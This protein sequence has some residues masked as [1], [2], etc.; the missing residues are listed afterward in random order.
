MDNPRKARVVE[1]HFLNLPGFNAGAYVRAYVQDTTHDEMR[2]PDGKH[3]GCAPTPR[4]VLEIADCY[5]H[6]RLEFDV[7]DA[8]DRL[9]AFHKI[10]VLI[11]A[12]EA[13]K[14]GMA[15]EAALRRAR[16]REIERVQ[17]EFDA[18]K[19]PSQAMPHAVLVS[20]SAA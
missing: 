9:N 4:L 1:Q 5:R 3:L 11:G 8:E 12:L 6:I 10:N 20:R 14:Q 2:L 19:D 7:Q 15:E 16:L 18:G 13:F 17:H